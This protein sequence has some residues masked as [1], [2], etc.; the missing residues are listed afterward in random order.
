M[1]SPAVCGGDRVEAVVL[2]EVL[3]LH[4]ALELGKDR[5]ERLANDVG[6]HREAPAVGHADDDLG[7]AVVGAAV[8]DV[9]QGSG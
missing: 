7:C 8:D 5:L 3:L 1:T 4:V 9:V 2:D 6:D